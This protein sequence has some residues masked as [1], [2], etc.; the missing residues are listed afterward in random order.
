MISE[1]VK[2]VD[3]G[4]AMKL[5][6][7]LRW[8]V[9]VALHGGSEAARR[10]GA[11]VGSE[12][13][14]LSFGIS[15][16]AWLVTIGSHVT[17]SSEVLFITHDGGGWLARDRRGRRFRYAPIHIGDSCFIGARATLMP[18]VHV[19]DNS[20]V[21]AGS[22][23]T[24]SVPEGSIVGGNPARLIGRTSQYL[25]KAIDTWPADA[26]VTGASSRELREIVDWEFLPEI[27]HRKSSEPTL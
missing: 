21:A 15:S 11:K 4:W 24:R 27:G 17:V 25:Q 8:R 10:M 6:S 20:I 19:G 16:E 18:G 7:G 1:A 14:I 23:V 2:G 3:V 12:C 5:P 22:V 9:L 13:R 26:E